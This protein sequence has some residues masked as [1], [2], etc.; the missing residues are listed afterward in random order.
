MKC[1][2]PGCERTDLIYSGVD[3]MMRGLPATEKYCYACGNAYYTI[4]QEVEALTQV[5][6]SN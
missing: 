4:K 2:T 1:K 6:V 5:E 3:A